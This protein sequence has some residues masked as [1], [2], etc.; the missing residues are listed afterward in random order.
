MSASKTMV[1]VPAGSATC[2]LQ[3]VALADVNVS[4][5]LPFT[6][7]RAVSLDSNEYTFE[8]NFS[9]APPEGTITVRVAIPVELRIRSCREPSGGEDEVTIDV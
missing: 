7:S 8:Q 5:V 6:S 4:T 9:V 2:Q 3:S 1:T